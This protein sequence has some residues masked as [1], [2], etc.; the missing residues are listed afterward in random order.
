[1]DA[2]WAGDGEEDA[3]GAREEAVGG[4]GVPR[5][6]L[7]AEGEEAD[8]GRGGAGR[9][10]GDGDAHHPEHVPRARCG[11]RAPRERA[12]VHRRGGRGVRGHPLL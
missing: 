11:Q 3:R 5:G 6:L 1:V 9:E 7:V 2:S 12:A 8:P 10:G 4:G